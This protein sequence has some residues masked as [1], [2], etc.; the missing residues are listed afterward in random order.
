[1]F[2]FKKIALLGAAGLAA[3]SM[4]C[5][6]PTD[7]EVGGTITGLAIENNVEDTYKLKGTVKV[8]EEG[9]KIK[10]ITIKAEKAVFASE[11]STV[12]LTDVNS[13]TK[14]LSEVETLAPVCVTADAGKNIEI[15]VTVTATFDTGSLVSQ[16]ATKTHACPAG[17]SDP[18]L[19]KSSTV[20]VG[21]T[22]SA[23]SFVDIDPATPVAY[24]SAQF[25]DHISE[26][27]I[28]Y[29][30]DFSGGDKIYS[31]SGAAYGDTELESSSKNFSEL[32]LAEG[33]IAEIY[34]LTSAQQSTVKSASKHSDVADIISELADREDSESV[35]ASNGTAFGVFTSN[36]NYKFVIINNKSTTV[37]VSII[38]VTIP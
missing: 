2:T 10:D 33:P 23:G 12:N 19:V 13:G 27:D 26:L 18:N 29:G 31:T 35:D 21:G 14:S 28:I 5:S 32:L 6:D 37:S 20:S 22:G 4:S 38:S 11:T 15:K 9:N 1:M 3:F 16:T 30:A 25:D 8:S 36:N 34:N 24:T 7:D 17:G